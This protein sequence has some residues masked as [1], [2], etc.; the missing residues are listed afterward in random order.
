MCKNSSG[1]PF[2]VSWIGLKS[3]VFLLNKTTLKTLIFLKIDF[4][5]F[6]PKNREVIEN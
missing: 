2:Q 4:Y 1:W 6:E 5:I 3:L